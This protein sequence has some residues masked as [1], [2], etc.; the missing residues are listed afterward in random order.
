MKR[1]ILTRP[2]DGNVLEGTISS[3][4]VEG[5][6]F[7]CATVERQWLDDRSDVSC[8][9]KGRYL[10]RMLYSDAHGRDVYHLVKMWDDDAQDWG[11]LED[12]RTEIEIHSANIFQQLKGCIA[13]GRSVEVFRAGVHPND[14]PGA[15]DQRG[16]TDSV[17]TV[18]EFEQ[19]M[20][21]EDFELIIQ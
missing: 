11:P 21:G 8:V 12:G 13:L 20:G 10:G 18:E 3:M 7:D 2:D 14:K 19:L 4:I 6:N 9:P 17:T 5:T 16:V 1:A 15:Y